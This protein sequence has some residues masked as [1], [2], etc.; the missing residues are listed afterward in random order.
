MWIIFESIVYTF[1]FAA[2]RPQP[3][4]RFAKPPELPHRECQ[5]VAVITSSTDNGIEYSL[6]LEN[7]TRIPI[8][9]YLAARWRE[10]FQQHNE[11][12]S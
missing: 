12:D 2:S 3:A 6:L 5:G 10:F 4:R 8:S 9:S 7:D 11:I 1:V